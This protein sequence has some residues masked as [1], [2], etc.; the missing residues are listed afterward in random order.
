[1]NI[2]LLTLLLATG[3]T[4]KEVRFTKKVNLERLNAELEAA[5]FK[6]SP[7]RTNCSGDNCVIYL[8]DTGP[9]N[10]AA[11]IKAHVY[12]PDQE[13][14]AARKSMRAELRALE[15]KL[16]DGTATMPEMRRAL[17]LLIKLH[18]LSDQP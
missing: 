10:P 9:Q 17:K 12:D 18:G 7:Y 2:F 15:K 11:V 8:L 16:D 6:L 1:M 13:P 14:L 4:A 5:G 3:A